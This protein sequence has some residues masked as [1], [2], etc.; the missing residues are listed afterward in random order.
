[1]FSGFFVRCENM[2]LGC[3]NNTGPKIISLIKKM[4]TIECS[5]NYWL[6][7]KTQDQCL[8]LQKSVACKN[9]MGICENTSS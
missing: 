9:T 2:V 7:Q 5:L 8:T 1:M 4:Q 6:T 3:Q